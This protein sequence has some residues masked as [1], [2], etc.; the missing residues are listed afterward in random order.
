MY[1]FMFSQLDGFYNFSTDRITFFL[2]ALLLA[3]KQR[4]N[5]ELEKN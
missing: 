1:V 4:E 2:R 5:L 3:C